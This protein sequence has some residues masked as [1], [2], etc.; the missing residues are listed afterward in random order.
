MPTTQQ[1]P[2]GGLKKVPASR[3]GRI[4]L[5][6]AVVNLLGAAGSLWASRS[7]MSHYQDSV[8]AAEESAGRVSLLSDLLRLAGDA[9]A[10]GN[11]V[12]ESK[13]PSKEEGKCRKRCLPSG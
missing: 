2:A 7:M 9:N 5:L 3:Q 10:P 1:R 6:L 8:L 12:F 11:D 4:Y 13:D